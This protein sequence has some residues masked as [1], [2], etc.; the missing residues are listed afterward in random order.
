MEETISVEDVREDEERSEAAD[1]LEA[2]ASTNRLVEIHD[3]VRAMELSQAVGYALAEQV[4]ARQHHL[5]FSAE[6]LL[7]FRHL[8]G[9]N[10]MSALETREAALAIRTQMG[11][12]Y[13]RLQDAM[14]ERRMP[15]VWREDGPPLSSLLDH[16]AQPLLESALERMC[17]IEAECEW[18]E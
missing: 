5:S 2:I 1:L 8:I 13:V 18:I 17:D 15:M 12:L 14:R 10:D 4:P 7:F 6:I 11:R 3:R 9:P 16:A